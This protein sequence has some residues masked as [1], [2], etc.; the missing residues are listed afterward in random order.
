MSEY[1][2]LA[3]KL[4]RQAGRLQMER[5]N[6]T[7]SVE[8]K[9]DDQLVTEVDKAC[10]RLIVEGIVANYPDHDIIAEE[11]TGE[12]RD[13]TF[14]WHIDPLD[15]T[16]NY[17]HRFP[18]FGV[19]IGLEKR[20]ELVMGT[21]YDP[22]RDELFAAEKGCGATL[23][24]APIH[25]SSVNRLKDAL[26]ATGFAYVDRS[27]SRVDNVDYFEAFL[28]TGRAVRRPGSASIDLAYVACGRLEGF[29]ELNLKPW[30]MAAGAL[31]IEEAGGKVTSFDGSRFDLY[32]TSIL[33]SN[34]LIHE[35]MMAILSKA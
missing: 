33:A 11:G 8:H 24:E 3:V 27:G 10:E 21:V 1:L 7:H 31:I 22:N 14:T 34:S 26:L 4:A 30:D 35:H 13:S 23:N 18:F 19:S 2:D 20:G 16:T 9:D 28:K 12:R 29:W 25:V 32:G 5:L 15:G 17:A 6:E